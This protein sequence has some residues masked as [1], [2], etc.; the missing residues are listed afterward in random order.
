MKKDELIE[1]GYVCVYCGTETK[2][3]CCGEVHHE[4]GF[5][6]SDG[7]LILESEI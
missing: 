5:E 6:D 7:N 3:P 2:E 1:I 4:V